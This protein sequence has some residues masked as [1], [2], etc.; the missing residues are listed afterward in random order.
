MPVA[1]SIYYHVYQEGE[2]LPLVLLH[3]AGGN[4][5]TWPPDIRRL[6][7][8]Q[9]YALDMPGHGRSAGRGQQSISG[10][11]QLVRDWMQAIDLHRSAFVGYS[12]GSA[13]AL[14][15]ALESPEQVIGLGLIGAAAKM[16]VNPQ[17]LEDTTSTTTFH[18]AVEQIVEWS[19]SPQVDPRLK[20]LVVQ[21]LAET[22]PSVLHGDFMACDGFD[23]S[24]QVSQ[25]SCPTLV[26]C[27][28]MDK[29]VPIRYAQFLVDHIAGARLE[30]VP[31]A[32][33]MVM[34][35]QP[36][37]VA[38]LLQQFMGQLSY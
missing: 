35:E 23:V 34:Q 36:Q 19:F 2:K 20:E 9:V 32:G 28:E 29:M 12:M 26:V 14:S 22:R 7:G 31:G 4:H 10:Y 24:D 15:L 3:G 18:N 37:A 17:L 27:G 25:V 21:R 13:I 8:Y 16:R 11:V 6:A 38:R 1:A 30:V 5:L 33:H